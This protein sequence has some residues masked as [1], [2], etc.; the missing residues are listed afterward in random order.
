MQTLP[1][2]QSYCLARGLYTI[3]E[4]FNSEIA[5]FFEQRSAG[6][7]GQAIDCIS[8]SI[9]DNDSQHQINQS[10]GDNPWLARVCEAYKSTLFLSDQAKQRARFFQLADVFLSSSLVPAY[11]VAA[12][13]KR[14]AR[15]ALTASP[16][17]DHCPF[18][19]S[20]VWIKH[21]SLVT[22]HQCP[23]NIECTTKLHRAP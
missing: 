17:G 8:S 15:L 5:F 11:T 18:S 16:A 22:D 4:Y 20:L 19:S 14:F 1:C 3:T 9:D 13:A 7:S 2:N 21:G 23:A 10:S 6:F 12:F